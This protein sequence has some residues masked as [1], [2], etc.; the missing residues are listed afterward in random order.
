M[1][2]WR[3]RRA[4]LLLFAIVAPGWGGCDTGFTGPGQQ[5]RMNV[6]VAEDGRLSYTIHRGDITIIE[7]SPLG[8]VVDECELG[9]NVVLGPV[10]RWQINETYEWRGA[11]SQAVNRCYC[12]EIQLTHKPTACS[13]RIELRL[14]AD[15]AAF[16]CVVPSKGPRRVMGESTA[17]RL[18]VGT[19][20]W[21][22][23]NTRNYEAVQTS[24]G[25][26]DVD[27]NVGLP[28]TLILPDESY[29][30]I[31]EADVF[32]YSGMTLK[33]TG[34]TTLRSVFKDNPQG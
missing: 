25:I 27:E 9:R 31:T 26:E 13:Y 33:H 3:S 11:H 32:G 29:A 8:I 23:T 28:V 18:P 2:L 10:K 20:L 14:F 1:W 24:C 6:F 4:A 17:F 21:Y 30:A 12:A 16:R 5:V 34:E 19:L 22:Q 7:P 15:G